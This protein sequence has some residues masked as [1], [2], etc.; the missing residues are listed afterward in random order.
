M[1]RTTLTRAAIVAAGRELAESGGVEAV[2]MRRV[3]ALLGCSAMALYRHVDDRAELLVLVLEDLAEGIDVAVP[4]GTPAERLT[5]LFGRL[6][7]Y[8]R[9]HAWAID[10]LRKG[11]LFAPRALHFVELALATLRGA[12]LDER[13]A[14]AAYLALWNFTVGSL[15][16]ER[17]TDDRAIA[18][19][20]ALI[21]RAP[22]DR[23]PQVT[24]AMPVLAATDPETA[25]DHGV[26][27]L[28]TGLLA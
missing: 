13:G 1:S 4:G 14:T 22:L 15:C 27:A 3:G 5:A 2:T 20:L 21:D 11:E 24:A 25:Y 6:F 28:V 9:A 16:S 7:R 18:R 19:R 23:L 8:L 12:G 10:V 17:P 26:R